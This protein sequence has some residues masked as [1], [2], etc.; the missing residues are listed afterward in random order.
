MPIS[1]FF[2]ANKGFAGIYILLIVLIIGAVTGGAYFL[3][4]APTLPVIQ[5]SIQATVTPIPTIT[6]TPTPIVWKTYTNSIYGFSLN[7]PKKGMILGEEDYFEDECGNSIKEKTDALGYHIRFDN[8]FEVK[9]IKREKN[10]EEYLKS[11]GAYKMYDLEPITGSGA[12]EAVKVIGLKKGSEIA[13]GY[14]PL[15]YT[16][17]IYKKGDNIFSVIGLENP[18]KGWEGCT[19]A[20]VLDPVA[21]AHLE[22]RDWDIAKSLKFN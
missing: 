8:F 17:H 14:P 11:I 18:N 15:M 1:Q 3:K 13:V 19:A 20:V 9:I 4:K 6:P 2:S 10:I 5:A 12:D 21:H 22:V 7:Y 16:T